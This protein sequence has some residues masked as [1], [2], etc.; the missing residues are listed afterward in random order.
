M[1]VPTK[2]GITHKIE[3]GTFIILE[4]AELGTRSVGF[5]IR[6]VD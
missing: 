1:H 4:K 5:Y 2:A 6:N 3:T